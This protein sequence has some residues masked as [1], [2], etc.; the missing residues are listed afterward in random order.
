MSSDED[1]AEEVGGEKY[2]VDIISNVSIY[3][4]SLSMSLQISPLFLEKPLSIS[5][6]ILGV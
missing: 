2:L 4:R 6:T 3:Q 1:T 5:P